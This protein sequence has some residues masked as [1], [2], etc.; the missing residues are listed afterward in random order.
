MAT[1]G[2]KLSGDTKMLISFFGLFY[3][4]KKAMSHKSRRGFR[5]MISFHKG[6]VAWGGLWRYLVR[7][8]H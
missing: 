5:L 3:S 1:K 6:L 8:V 4:P 7:K 2:A